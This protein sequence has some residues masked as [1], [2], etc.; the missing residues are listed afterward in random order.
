MYIQVSL[1]FNLSRIPTGENYEKLR[2]ENVKPFSFLSEEKQKKEKP[3][4]FIDVN[5]GLGR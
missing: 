1:N 3:F 2:K 5:V 4:V